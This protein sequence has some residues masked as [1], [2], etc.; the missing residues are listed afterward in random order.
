MKKALNTV[1]G[2]ADATE[3]KTLRL[4]VSGLETMST[5][6]SSSVR[7]LQAKRPAAMSA[8]TKLGKAMI[9]P[10]Y[11][12]SIYCLYRILVMSI[13]AIRRYTSST[14]GK[15][16]FATLDPVSRFL[17]LLATHIDPTLDTAAWSRQISFFLTGLILLLSFNSVVQTFYLFARWTPG[18]LHQAQANLALIIAQICA[19]YV[20]A[21]ALLLRSN[22]PREVGSVISEALGTPLDVRFV[23]RF[24]EFWFLTGVTGTGIG[25]FVGRKLGNGE[26]SEDWDDGVDVEVGHKRS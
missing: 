20:I 22:L 16:D 10:T 4:E 19:T 5:S 11:L 13:T 9:L 8:Q 15:Q 3:L 18:L 12:F 17:S 1:R 14:Y 24:F 26:G 21:S 2:N 25:I 6:L 23:D 7:M